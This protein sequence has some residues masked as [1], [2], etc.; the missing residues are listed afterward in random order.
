[1]TRPGDKYEAFPGFSEKPNNHRAKKMQHARLF[2]ATAGQGK[3]IPKDTVPMARERNSH[4]MIVFQDIWEIS[5]SEVT[6]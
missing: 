5:R 6:F 1:M 3:V 2:P 4:T